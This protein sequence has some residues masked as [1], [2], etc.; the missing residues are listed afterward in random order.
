MLDEI[1]TGERTL[2]RVSILI[3]PG[4]LVVNFHELFSNLFASREHV[5]ETSV[6]ITAI[7]LNI[8]EL[9]RVLSVIKVIE[10]RHVLSHHFFF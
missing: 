4:L 9:F 2:K 7:V 6:R 8:A 5:G 3:R 10:T 1:E